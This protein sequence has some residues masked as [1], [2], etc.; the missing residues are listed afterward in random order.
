MLDGCKVLDLTQ[1]LAGPGVTRMLAELGADIIKIEL[2][3]DG[4]GGRMLPF[5]VGDRSGFFIQQN[6]GKRSLCVDWSTDEGLAL[7]RSLVSKVD[8]VVENFGTREI[9]AGRGLDYDSLKDEFP[10]LIYLSISAFGRTSPWAS[11]P[12]F[13]FIAQAASGIMHMNGEPDRAP[14]TVWSALGDTNA[15]VHGFAALG[16]ALYHRGRTGEGQ[17][18]DLAMTDCLFHFHD[19]ALQG[20]HL[21]GGEYVPKRYGVHHKL[22]FP[23]GNFKGPTG[24]ITILALHRQWPNLCNALGRPDLI[25]DERYADMGDR[26]ARAPELVELVEAWLASFPSDDDA[27][28]EL[29]RHRVPAV[30]VLSPI[31]AIDH[32]H[33]VARDMVRWVDDRAIGTLPIPGFPF[34]FGA[35]PTLPDLQAPFLGEHNRQILVDELGFAT[36]EIDD[37][38]AR[39]VLFDEPIPEA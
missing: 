24:W 5:K 21:S 26:A 28:A 3:P 23:G 14:S 37:L 32:P 27:V 33:F 34:K 11:K 15:A 25:D 22:I 12:G 31:D 36:D 8:I 35:Q 38:I 13:D 19:T 18:I 9:L 10:G 20:Y 16:Y 4:D 1:Y 7:I 2:A 6:R 39:K 17:F 29:D 30:R